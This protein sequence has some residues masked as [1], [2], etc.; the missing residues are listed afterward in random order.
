[1]SYVTVEAFPY[2]FGNGD[3]EYSENWLHEYYLTALDAGLSEIQ[4]I[5]YIECKFL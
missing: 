4:M 2:F 3:S 5:Q 1:M